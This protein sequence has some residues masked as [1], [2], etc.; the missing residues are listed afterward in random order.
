MGS[1]LNRVCP[2]RSVSSSKEFLIQKIV[3]M[4]LLIVRWSWKI[5][6]QMFTLNLCSVAQCPAKP[7]SKTRRG[8]KMKRLMWLIKKEGAAGV[9]QAEGDRRG[10]EAMPS[11]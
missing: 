5:T 11:R 10:R 4:A 7:E 3:V 6:T 2:K 8:W 9:V 1:H